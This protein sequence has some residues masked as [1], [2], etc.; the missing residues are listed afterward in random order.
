MFRLP[1]DDS[2]SNNGEIVM[3]TDRMY[4]ATIRAISVAVEGEP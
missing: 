3:Q 1:T 2:W 4:P